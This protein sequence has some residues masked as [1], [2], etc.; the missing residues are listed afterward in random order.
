MTTRIARVLRAAGLV[1][2]A[3]AMDG[4]LF[5]IFNRDQ[6][7]LD[8]PLSQYA[9]AL[10][11]AALF[12]CSSWSLGLLIVKKLLPG[13]TRLDERLALG[14]VFGILAFHFCV[15]LLGV[16]GLLNRPACLLLPL[17]FLVAGA[18]N[19]WSMRRRISQLGGVLANRRRPQTRGVKAHWLGAFTLFVLAG[20]CLTTASIGYDSAWYHLPVAEIYAARHAIR[21]FADGWYLGAFPQLASVMYAWG[22]VVA[23]EPALGLTTSAF[24][25]LT[26]VASA[27]FG[28]I[29]CVR[30]LSPVRGRAT[31]AWATIALFPAVYLY[32]P[33]IEA[34]Y[35]AAAFA[36]ALLLLTLRAYRRFEV[37]EL[38]GWATVLGGV[39]LVKYSAVS[40]LA[41]PVLLIGIRA[42]HRLITPAN[43]RR[44]AALALGAAAGTFLL[45]TTPHWLKNLVFYGD[46]LFPQLSGAGA[47]TTVTR[48]YYLDFLKALWRPTP[49]W[50]GVVETVRAMATFSFEPHEYANYNA[51]HPIFGSLFS[52]TLLP[53]LVLT[54]ARRAL[55]WQGAV[56]LGVCVWFRIH[57]QDRYLLALLPWMCA[58]TGA[59]IRELCWHGPLLRAIA[60][61]ACALQFAVGVRW[62]IKLVPLDAIRG[63]LWA[64]TIADWRANQLQRW[65]TMVRVGRSLPPGATLMVHDERIRLGLERN[66][67]SDAQGWQTRMSFVEL[68]NSARIY[69]RLMALGVTHLFAQGHS[70][71][72]DTVGSDLVYYS[73]F[74]R[75]GTSTTEVEVRHMPAARPSEERA[76]TR[77][78]FVQ[79]CGAVSS[80]TGLYRVIDLDDAQ[81]GTPTAF[82]AK[83][84]QRVSSKAAEGKRDEAIAR[85]EFLV[86]G[87]GCPSQT[88]PTDGTFQLLT[89]RGNLLL[90]GRSEAAAPESSQ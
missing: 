55:V 10:A 29:P 13:R 40:L 24:I 22:M 58:V 54:R 74:Y 46:P 41:F 45:V 73:F 43:G 69:D 82:K 8:S 26:F 11:I 78:A 89:T 12:A 75:Y 15:W 7:V 80:P 87:D 16:L 79:S 49:G 35:A 25:E 53:L 31:W 62:A 39:S 36:P 66:S 38:V 57:H 3:L 88:T 51:G 6:P 63:A 81:L 28:V 67:L 59:T 44:T 14:F 70:D 27:I 71:G 64:P 77:L 84:V 48:Q 47:F 90:Y 42:C 9:L 4:G 2:S 33:R 19:A 61:A 76:D 30:A 20:H 60:A 65:P 86:L 56:L 34:D 37:R 83:P 21:P 5:W 32:P 50:P 18:R 1:C 68:G 17:V 72:Q 23:R 52:A 85:A